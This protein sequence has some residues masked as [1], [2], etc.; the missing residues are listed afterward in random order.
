LDAWCG[1]QGQH[2]AAERLAAADAFIL[3]HLADR[4]RDEF[5]GGITV[6]LTVQRRQLG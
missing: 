3:G 5:D 2:G 4:R 1:H 6:H